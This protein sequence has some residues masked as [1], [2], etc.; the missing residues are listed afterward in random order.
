MKTVNDMRCS[1]ME[2]IHE[3]RRDI[4][5][6]INRAQNTEKNQSKIG[7]GK[8]LSDYVCQLCLLEGKGRELTLNKK[9]FARSSASKNLVEYMTAC[10]RISSD[11]RR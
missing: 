10:K 7:R 1:C 2:R 11:T 6:G 4:N 5:D 9:L 8:I 3:M